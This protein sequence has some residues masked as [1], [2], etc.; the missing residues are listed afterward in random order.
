MHRAR[1]FSE[2]GRRIGSTPVP[3]WCLIYRDGKNEGQSQPRWKES[4]RHHD[5]MTDEISL[6]FQSVC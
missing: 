2:K 6:K 4:S 3:N 1:Y 5:I